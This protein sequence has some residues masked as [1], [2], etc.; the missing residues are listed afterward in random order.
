MISLVLVSLALAGPPE[1][2]AAALHTRVVELLSGMESSPD[3][4]DWAA[5]GPAAEAELLAVAQDATAL[6]TRRGN[7]LV[8][9]GHFPTAAAF[10]LLTHTLGD[11]AAP[12]LLR[13]KACMGLAAGWGAAAVPALGAA[14]AEPS[15]LLRQSAARALGTVDDPAAEAALRRR[16]AVESDASVLAVIGKAVAR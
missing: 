8:A 2:A 6:P 15:V 4:A 10:A 5:L 3:A 1:P 16:L 13:R 11:A 9:L 14:L 12:E 7:A